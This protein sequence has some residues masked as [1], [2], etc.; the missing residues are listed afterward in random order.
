MVWSLGQCKCGAFSYSSAHY[1]VG[2][3]LFL[4]SLVL[5]SFSSELML[6]VCDVC[7]FKASFSSFPALRLC[8]FCFYFSVFFSLRLAFPVVSVLSRV[9][10][11][12][13]GALLMLWSP[14]PGIGSSY[15]VGAVGEYFF[16]V[17]G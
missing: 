6:C 7:W 3:W 17:V 13:V 14:I 15:Y 2:V 4:R 8:S 10:V 12:G 16:A 9:V 1:V 11:P 5:T